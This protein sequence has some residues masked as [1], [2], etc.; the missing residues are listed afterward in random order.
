MHIRHLKF[1]QHNI[2]NNDQSLDFEDI[3][4]GGW[5]EN[6]PGG[7]DDEHASLVP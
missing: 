2:L 7:E 1:Y 4:L 3:K 5:V 6:E